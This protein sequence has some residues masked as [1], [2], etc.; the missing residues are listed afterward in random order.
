[1]LELRSGQFALLRYAHSLLRVLEDG[2]VETR[3]V[4]NAVNADKLPF[5]SDEEVAL[6]RRIVYDA[7]FVKDIGRVKDGM[8]YCTS[9]MGRLP[10]AVKRLTPDLSFQTPDSMFHVEIAT[11]RQL[12]FAPGPSGIVAVSQGVSEVMNP[13]LFGQLDDPPMQFTGLLYDHEHQIVLY[14][15]GHP[16][17]LPTAEILTQKVVTHAGIVYQ[18]LCSDRYAVCVIGVEPVSAMIEGRPGFLVACTTGGALVGM[19]FTSTT[20]LL[21]RRQRS[22]EHRLRR[23]VRTRRLCCVYQPIVSLESNAV[24]GAEALARWTTRAGE[25]IPPDT[26]IPVAEARGFVGEITRLVMDRV[27]DDLRR[28]LGGPGFQVSINITAQDLADPL[29]FNHLRELVAESGIAPHALAFELTERSRT[30]EEVAKNGI[31]RLRAAGHPVYIDDFGTGYSSLAYLHDLRVDAIKIDRVF[32]Q[33]IGTESVIGVVLPQIVYMA[34]RLGLIVVVEGVETEDQ[35]D[36]FRHAASGILGQGYFL[37]RPVPAAEFKQIFAPRI[38]EV[39]PKNTAS[40][41]YR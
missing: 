17:T 40:E 36:Y 14:G 30:D 7:T 13:S 21:F 2:A 9:A 35:A 28:F 37:G 29:F 23:A 32:T 33:T 8:L 27:V 4:A 16:E 5:C 39:A 38:A 25:A 22:L 12:M 24:V 18:P 6:M 19:F 34:A 1:M 26:F 3:Q 20:L 31:A 10:R 15:A 11:S 41:T